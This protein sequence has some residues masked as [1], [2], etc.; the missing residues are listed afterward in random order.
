M[1]SKPFTRLTLLMLGLF[2]QVAGEAAWAQQ[3][4]EQG[5]VRESVRRIER[6]TGGRVL[7]IE[8]IQHN[9]QDIYRMKVLTPGGRVRVMQERPMGRPSPRPA[10]S[11]P[12]LP[13]RERPARV[14]PAERQRAASPSGGAN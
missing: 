4:A 12:A 3:T 2:V 6:E 7:R 10:I 11:R 1:N 14:V 5:Q 8:S 9:G 13:E